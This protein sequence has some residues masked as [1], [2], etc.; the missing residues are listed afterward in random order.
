MLHLTARHL[1]TGS[2]VVA[3]FRAAV[4]VPRGSG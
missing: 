2:I 4:V 3:S 1:V